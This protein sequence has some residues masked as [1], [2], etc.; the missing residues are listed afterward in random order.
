MNPITIRVDGV[1]KPG[2]SKTAFAFKGKDGRPHARV[3]DAGKGNRE[4]KQLVAFEA[5]RQYT[6]PPFALLP[7][8]VTFRFTMPRPKFH[9]RA[10]RN[11]HLLRPDAPKY[12]IVM[13]DATK[14]MRSTEDALTG[15]LWRD[16][17]CV[18]GFPTK[19]YGDRPGVDITVEVLEP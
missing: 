10:G 6:D 5:R 8:L 18:F 1:P 7:L 4:W 2:G 17:A 19:V 3:V 12:H 16:D 15:I 11:A 13:P 9:Y 14:L